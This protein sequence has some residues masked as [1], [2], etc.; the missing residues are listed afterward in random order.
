MFL[1]QSVVGCRTLNS[2][3]CFA[4]FLPDRENDYSWGL[5]FRGEDWCE[6]IAILV[7]KQNIENRFILPQPRE[8]RAHKVAFL[9]PYCIFLLIIIAKV[10][11]LNE[12]LNFQ[13]EWLLSKNVSWG[14]RLRCFNVSNQNSDS[15][16][17]CLRCVLQVVQ[18]DPFGHYHGHLDSNPFEPPA[19][20]CCHQNHFKKRE[21]R[22]C[23]Y[24]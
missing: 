7:I 4:L 23:R 6:A 19:M 18:Y 11:S 16:I 22:V 8:K 2:P 17:N 13:K 12:N 24:W 14:R 20:P 15:I 5:I 21:C 1:I 9:S 10:R 3:L